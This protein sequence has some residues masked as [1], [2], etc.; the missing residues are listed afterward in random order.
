MIYSSCIWVLKRHGPYRYLSIYAA[1]YLRYSVELYKAPVI[2]SSHLC[3][4]VSERLDLNLFYTSMN[5]IWIVGDI[6]ELKM[7]EAFQ[8]ARKT[9]FRTEFAWIVIH[10]WIWAYSMGIG[11]RIYLEIRRSI[12]TLGEMTGECTKWNLLFAFLTQKQT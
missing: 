10:T 2:H 3:I 7:V 5:R 1:S 6:V 12:F 4:Y 8:N 11:I 9:C